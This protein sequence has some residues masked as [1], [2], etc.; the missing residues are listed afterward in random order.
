MPEDAALEAI[1]ALI[2]NASRF[3]Q[4]TVIIT[5]GAMPTLWVTVTD[6]GPGIPADLRQA[7][8]TRGSRLDERSGSHGLGLAIA[9]DLVI[10]N[11]GVLDLEDAPSGGLTVRINWPNKWGH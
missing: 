2:E 9:Q 4:S 8:L 6:N 7:A 11:G 1:G 10:A 5:A 3:A